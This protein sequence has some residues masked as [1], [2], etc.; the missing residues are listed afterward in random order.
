[1]AFLDASVLIFAILTNDTFILHHG[2]NNVYQSYVC[3][4]QEDDDTFPRNWIRLTPSIQD[5]MTIFKASN[6]P[7]TT[8]NAQIVKY[9]LRLIFNNSSFG[10]SEWK[11]VL[12]E[13]VNAS[14][15]EHLA[16]NNSVP[17]Q[18]NVSLKTVVLWTLWFLLF[19]Y[20]VLH[21]TMY[22]IKQCFNK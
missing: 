19:T 18:I 6:I 11:Q 21:L 5:G 14:P 12:N 10:E 7:T 20:Y 22:Y 3:F 15:M 13:S 8:T 17:L 9:K 4:N 2:V 1:M 16:R